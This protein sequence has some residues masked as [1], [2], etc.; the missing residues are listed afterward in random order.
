MMSLKLSMMCVWH[1]YFSIH[2]SPNN[3]S[4]VLYRY[5]F[6]KPS[7]FLVI[8]IVFLRN[9]H[10][11]FSFL[12][13]SLESYTMYCSLWRILNSQSVLAICYSGFCFCFCLVWF[14]F[15]LSYF[16]KYQLSSQD[17]ILYIYLHRFLA[18]AIF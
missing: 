4:S 15:I 18:F 14:G 7:L 13:S 8:Y 9:K 17:S 5:S 10:R 16:C 6:W 11:W 2:R 3:I 1:L 12:L